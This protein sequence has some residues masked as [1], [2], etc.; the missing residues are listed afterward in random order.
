MKRYFRWRPTILEQLPAN[1][2][3]VL[4][5]SL[6]QKARAVSE[7]RDDAATT[8]IRIRAKKSSE[9]YPANQSKVTAMS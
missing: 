7:N 4:A 6:V 5:L 3:E 2:A 8:R 9:G 1:K